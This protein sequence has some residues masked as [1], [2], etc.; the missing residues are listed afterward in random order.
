MR[1]LNDDPE[2]Y[3]RWV[4]IV[5]MHFTSSYMQLT[6]QGLE[7]QTKNGILSY[8]KEESASRKEL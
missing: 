2:P 4:I 1:E 5:L 6:A 7:V 3:W 8:R